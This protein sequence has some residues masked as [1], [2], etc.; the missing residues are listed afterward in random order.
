[1]RELVLEVMSRRIIMRR[2]QPRHDALPI[3][4]IPE[5]HADL[6]VSRISSR[7]RAFRRDIGISHTG[8]QQPANICPQCG[9]VS[10]HAQIFGMR[11]CYNKACNSL[12]KEEKAANYKAPPELVSMDDLFAHRGALKTMIEN[13]RWPHYHSMPAGELSL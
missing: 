8:I 9:Y 12:F 6:W 4:I 1:M 11:R 7:I 2:W 5:R 3:G 13:D 10:K